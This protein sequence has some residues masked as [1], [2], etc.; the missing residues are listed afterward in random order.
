MTPAEL[1][2]EGSSITRALRETEVTPQ[3]EVYILG[4]RE[5]AEVIEMF[6]KTCALIENC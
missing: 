1:S 4:M 6:K 3:T 5:R 2:Y